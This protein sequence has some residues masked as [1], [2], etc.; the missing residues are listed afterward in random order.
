MRG[1]ALDCDQEFLALYYALRKLDRHKTGEVGACT[2]WDRH[3]GDCEGMRI[4]W[5]SC[6]LMG[7]LELLR[8]RSHMR[9]LQLRPVDESG[10][11]SRGI[12]PTDHQLIRQVH[13]LTRV[14]W[15]WGG[16]S[17]VEGLRYEMRVGWSWVVGQ[18]HLADCTGPICPSSWD[19]G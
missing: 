19:L 12:A 3:K 14:G 1:N 18:S 16:R 7:R 6:E 4:S 13:E 5:K 2:E 15:R 9:G 8:K 10:A 17:N 11:P